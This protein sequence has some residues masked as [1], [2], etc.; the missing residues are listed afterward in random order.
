MNTFIMTLNNRNLK[1]VKLSI[2][3]TTFRW[4]VIVIIVSQGIGQIY[5]CPPPPT[6]FTDPL[7]THG[8]FS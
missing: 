2:D 5:H 1:N 8:F 7:A 6:H 4:T 3:L